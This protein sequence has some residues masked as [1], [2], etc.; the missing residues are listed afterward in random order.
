MLYE[1]CQQKL[2]FILRTSAVFPTLQC[3]LGKV[4]MIEVTPGCRLHSMADLLLGM[5]EAL[6][7][8]PEML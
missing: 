3:H 2:N 8:S 1:T 7:Q 4:T 6:A 5:P